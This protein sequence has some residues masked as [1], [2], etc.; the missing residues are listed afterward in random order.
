MLLAIDTATR[1]VS[2]ALSDGQNIL[3]ESTWNTANHHTVELTPALHDLLARA[4]VSP[5][6][7]TALAVTRGP[8]S[9]T[10]LRIGMSL[11]KGLALAAT[12]PLPIVNIPT[13]DVTAVAQPHHTDRLCAV[14]QAGRK[15]INA[16]TYQWVEDQGWLAE[17]DPF[18]TVWTELLDVLKGDWQIA[19]EID[20][21]GREA[22]SHAP[23]ILVASPAAGLRRAG[24]LAELAHRQLA[25][26]FPADPATAAPIYL[27]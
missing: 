3:A 1:S 24:Y 6:S 27:T 10:G 12:P 8:G 23:H 19:G 17:G 18:I 9:Y 15:R 5:S 21:T 16:G 22:L 4:G 11:A 7:L 14:A 20:A 25:A 26:G 13:L 2:L